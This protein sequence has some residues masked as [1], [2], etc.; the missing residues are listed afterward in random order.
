MTDVTT[1][2]RQQQKIATFKWVPYALLALPALF[3]FAF[4]LGAS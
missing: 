1:T 3:A 4:W 2:R